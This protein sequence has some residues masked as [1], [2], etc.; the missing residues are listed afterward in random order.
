[1]RRSP[2]PIAATKAATPHG[3]ADQHLRPAALL[4]DRHLSLHRRPPGQRGLLHE[5]VLDA[6]A[7]GRKPAPAVAA[8]GSQHQHIVKRFAAE[9][10]RP[11]APM[12]L[13]LRSASVADR[14]RQLEVALTEAHDAT[15]L[16]LASTG[17][18]SPVIHPSGPPGEGATSSAV[19]AAVRPRFPCGQRGRRIACC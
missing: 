5:L 19:E 3:G 13:S 2:L 16:P 7:R 14:H 15:A 9:D 1:M 4:A 8:G 18:F 12:V 11:Q 6:S 10:E 17:S